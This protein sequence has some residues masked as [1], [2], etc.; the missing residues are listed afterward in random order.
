MRPE[1]R[2]LLLFALRGLQ[3]FLVCLL[4]IVFLL[5]ENGLVLVDD[6]CFLLTCAGLLLAQLFQVGAPPL[7]TVLNLVQKVQLLVF[8]SQAVD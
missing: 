3:S 4:D 6:G 8:L 1:P 7:L 5:L 2:Q